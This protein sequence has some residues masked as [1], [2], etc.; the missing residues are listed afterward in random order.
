MFLTK[1]LIPHQIDVPNKTYSI[2]KIDVPNKTY[3]IYKI[4]VP[5]KTPHSTSN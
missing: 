1:H 4:D 2:Y 5:N 3:S